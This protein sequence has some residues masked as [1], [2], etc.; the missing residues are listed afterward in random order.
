MSQPLDLS[1]ALLRPLAARL[2]EIGA[3]GAGMLA[4]LA[5]IPLLYLARAGIK[6]YLGADEAARLRN[7]AAA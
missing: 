7:D 1:V 2:D 5:M 4:A 3:D 6:A